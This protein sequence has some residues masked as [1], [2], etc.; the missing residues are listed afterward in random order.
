MK[1]LYLIKAKEVAEILDEKET[2]IMQIVSKAYV[3]HTAGESSLPNS[4]FL[5]F[6]NNGLNRIIGLPAYLRG[7]INA[8]GMKWISSF[9]DNINHGIER[10]SALMI[11]NNIE[12]G[13]AEVVLE[14]SIISSKRTAAS[15]ALAAKLIHSNPDETVLGFVGCGRINR[16]ISMFLKSAFKNV[17]K[18][19]AYD[20]DS[21]R[22]EGFLDDIKE[23]GMSTTVAESVYD[24][25]RTALLVSFATTVGTPYIHDIS[26]CNSDSTILNIS[27]RDFGPEVILSADN[28]VDDLEHVCRERTA[29]HLA[30]QTCGNR[31]FVRCPIAD[32]I[33]GKQKG[34]MEGKT[35]IYSPFGLGVL[36]LALADYVRKQA[37]EKG[38]GTVIEN[39]LP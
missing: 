26:A 15:A 7:N 18:L 13:H 8:A 38:M 21:K 5:R 12:N 39:F 11:L 33:T 36:D 20:L 27:L 31:D 16:E 6:P 2:E 19:I 30:E 14:G 29:I 25:F 9:P 37:K 10:A 32:V 35:V 3:L 23:N 22:A 4:I 34:R 24:V 1:E 28:I 17:K